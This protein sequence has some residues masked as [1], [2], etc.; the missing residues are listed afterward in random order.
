MKKLKSFTL[1]ELL[2]AVTITALVVE[3]AYFASTIGQRTFKTSTEKIELTQ[4]ARVVLD[5]LSRELRQAT[6]VTTELPAT[7]DDPELP[8][9]NTIQ[10]ED[11][12]T[13]ITQYIKYELD[14]TTIRRKL[15]AYY[16]GSSLPDS[17]EWV[18]AGARDSENNPP[19]S[20]EITNEVIAENVS[21][22]TFYGENVIYINMAV[23]KEGQ[24]ENFATAI[25]ARNL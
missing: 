8:P 21:A 6:E 19:S 14:G 4:N 3:A 20:S 5:R 24:T 10:F 18:V 15:I 1:S 9:S 13:E 12:H 25:N 16:F 22:L 23:T 2:I 11:G 17:S 7:T